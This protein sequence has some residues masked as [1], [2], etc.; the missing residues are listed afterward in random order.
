MH[1]S[2]FAWPLKWI[3]KRSKEVVGALNYAATVFI[4]SSQN[5]DHPSQE[6]PGWFTSYLEKVSTCSSRGFVCHLHSQSFMQEGAGGFP[7][8]AISFLKL[9]S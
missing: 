2:V 8:Q 4:C 7:K 6:P 3:V 9:T 1:L 5:E